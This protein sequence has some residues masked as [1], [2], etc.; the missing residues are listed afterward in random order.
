MY[1]NDNLPDIGI[2]THMYP[3]WNYTNLYQ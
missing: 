1:F 3:A 2:H